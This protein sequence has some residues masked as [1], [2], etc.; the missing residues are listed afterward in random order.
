[1][2]DHVLITGQAGDRYAG[3]DP[4]IQRHQP[5]RPR[6]AHAHAS[7]AD[8]VSDPPP[9][10]TPD[11]PAPSSRR[12]A[13]CPRTCARPRGRIWR[14][15]PRRRNFFPPCRRDPGRCA[16]RSIRVDRQ[17]NVAAFC[18]SRSGRFRRVPRLKQFLFAD[19]VF[20]PVPVAVEDGGRG[21]TFCARCT[22]IRRYRTTIQS[23]IMRMTPRR[24]LMAGRMSN[25]IQ[26]GGPL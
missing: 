8:P 14:S 7:H 5:P 12:A 26:I 1:M 3:L 2:F 24:T 10:A 15:F 18:E 19:L 25:C 11:N 4:F 13:T 6:R 16:H 17:H 22:L 21:Q 9:A 20:S 23:S